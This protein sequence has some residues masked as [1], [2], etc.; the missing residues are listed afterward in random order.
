MEVKDLMQESITKVKKVNTDLV[1]EAQPLVDTV[2]LRQVGTG[3]IE[4]VTN[5]QFEEEYDEC[6]GCSDERWDRV[7]ERP[8]GDDNGE[9]R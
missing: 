2:L 7:E 3:I 9:R 6:F 4:Q 1:Y 8:Q 5:E